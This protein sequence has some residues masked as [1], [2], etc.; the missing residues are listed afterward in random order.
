MTASTVTCVDPRVFPEQLLKLNMGEAFVFRTIAG[1]PQAVF[2]DVVTLDAVS[3]GFEDL[4]LLYHTGQF[5]KLSALIER[6]A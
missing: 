5:I 1:H 3:Q 2:Q 6:I 4:I